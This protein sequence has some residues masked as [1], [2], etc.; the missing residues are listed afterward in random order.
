MLVMFLVIAT[1]MATTGCSSASLTATFLKVR[2]YESNT[3]TASEIEVFMLG[4]EPRRSHTIVADLSTDWTWHGLAA[5]REA[6]LR[7]MKE[8]AAEHGCDGIRDVRFVPPGMVSEGLGTGQ[9]FVYD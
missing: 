5:D 4:D 9:A 2:S 6:V 8:T 1:S 3:R 7:L